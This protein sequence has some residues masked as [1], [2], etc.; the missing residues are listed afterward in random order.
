VH[1]ANIMPLERPPPLTVATV[2]IVA[3]LK[4][5]KATLREAE[6]N[7]RM[8]EA[9]RRALVSTAKKEAA[10][11]K[12]LATS[13]AKLQKEHADTKER[14][15]EQIAWCSDFRRIL[16]SRTNRFQTTCSPPS[17]I[18]SEFHWKFNSECHCDSRLCA[19]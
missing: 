2:Y 19:A 10:S 12:T 17:R 3:T 15:V 13:Y 1:V 18:D 11:A 14:E 5:A 6:D 9:A 7:I 16:R 8:L 4:A